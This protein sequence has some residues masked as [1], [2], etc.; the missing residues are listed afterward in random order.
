MNMKVHINAHYRIS[1]AST[2]FEVNEGRI[3]L[4]HMGYIK[5]RITVLQNSSFAKCSVPGRYVAF[6]VILKCTTFE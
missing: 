2:H 4:K 3:M 1:S 6:I 5:G